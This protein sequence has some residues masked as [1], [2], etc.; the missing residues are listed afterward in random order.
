MRRALHERPLLHSRSGAPP[1]TLD[2]MPHHHSHLV[3]AAIVTATVAL[4]P[5][6]ASAQT[7]AVAKGALATE[8]FVI[9]AIDA[10]TRTVTLRDADGNTESIVCGP[11]VQR[12]D[13]L[14]VGDKVTFRYYESVVYRIGKPGAGSKEA[15]YA[16]GISRAPGKTP[17]GTIAE[18]VTASVTVNAIDMKMPSIDVTTP[19]KIRMT[20]KVEDPKNLEGVKVG[21]TVE[22]TYTQALAVSVAPAK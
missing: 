21:D 19:G 10:K 20:L 6:L 13:A 11:E 9:Q 12:F 5:L 3:Y 7:P 18:Q 15:T 14:K 1:A 8:T 4:F 22:I 16:G 17:G 2:P